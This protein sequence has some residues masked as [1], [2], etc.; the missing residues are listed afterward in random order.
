ML[1]TGC[2]SRAMGC[3]GGMGCCGILGLGAV[4]PADP[5]STGTA[6]PFDV[7]LVISWV[8]LLWACYDTHAGQD[9]TESLMDLALLVASHV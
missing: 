8:A 6:R 7:R 4:G 5:C 1:I 9:R 3:C 2:G